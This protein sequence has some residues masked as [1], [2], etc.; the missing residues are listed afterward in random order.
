MK[1]SVGQAKRILN[2]KEELS[3]FVLNWILRW[4]DQLCKENSYPP[5]LI[6]G[7]FL[8]NLFLYFEPTKSAEILERLRKDFKESHL[9]SL[10][11]DRSKDFEWM[12]LKESF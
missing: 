8:S 4:I 6:G 12:D 1:I 9:S 5:Q 2:T 3:P 11:V 7:N 10:P